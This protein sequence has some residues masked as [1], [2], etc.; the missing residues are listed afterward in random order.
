MEQD[1][2]RRTKGMYLSCQGQEQEQ[3]G[4]VESYLPIT[5]VFDKEKDLQ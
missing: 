4:G 1:A 2:L 3:A 5:Y